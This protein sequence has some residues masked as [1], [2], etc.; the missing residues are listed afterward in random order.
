MTDDTTPPPVASAGAR[1]PGQATVMESAKRTTRLGEFLASSPPR[2][3]APARIRAPAPIPSRRAKPRAAPVVRRGDAI[4]ES[5]SIA[6]SVTQAATLLGI[7]RTLAWQLVRSGRLPA[8]RLPDTERVVVLVA[9][10]QV[11][12]TSLEPYT[13][14]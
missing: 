12:A 9:D 2:A 4:L 5:L 14:S 6:V 3:A 7:G 8:R 1:P 13:A 10:L 11:F